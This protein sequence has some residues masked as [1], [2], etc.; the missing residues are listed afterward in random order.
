MLSLPCQKKSFSTPVGGGDHGMG[1]GIDLSVMIQVGV[2]IKEFQF[3]IT[4]YLV[5][6]ERTTETIFGGDIRGTIIISIT[7]TSKETGELGIIPII[8]ID[9]KIAS[10]HITT[11]GDCITK[12]AI[13]VALI[14]DMIEVALK[15][16]TIKGNN[17]IEVAL[18][19]NT[20]K[21]NNGIE[22]ALKGNTI[23]GN[24]QQAKTS[25][26]N[27]QRWREEFPRFFPPLCGL[28]TGLQIRGLIYFK[29][30]FAF[31]KNGP[32]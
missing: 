32:V 6:G 9:R 30:I 14:K 31:F 25:I 19:G 27:E 13:G 1:A 11:M 4:G 3:G 8:G 7:V 5:I 22:V 28:V 21:G 17:A 2:S 29:C 16:N 15:G 12:D 24:I 18:K 23:K 10:L 20:I 26:P